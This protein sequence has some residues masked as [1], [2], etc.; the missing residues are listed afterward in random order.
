MHKKVLMLAIHTADHLV[1]RGEPEAAADVLQ[2]YLAAHA[3]RAQV[4]RRLG[5]VRL[6][7]GRAAEA[8]ELLEQ[9]L[10]CKEQHE[11][12]LGTV[13]LGEEQSPNAAAQ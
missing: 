10:A 12:S 6:S 5:R 7:Q 2:R 13:Q 1:D 4:L 8:A 3:P 9:A 11:E